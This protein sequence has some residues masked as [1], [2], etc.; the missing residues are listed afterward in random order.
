MHSRAT[1]TDKSM[2]SDY[3]HLV[4]D[5]HG[6]TCVISRL[7]QR[8]APACWFFVAINYFGG[9]RLAERRSRLDSRVREDLPISQDHAERQ[10]GADPSAIYDSS[11]EVL[12]AAEDLTNMPSAQRS[13]TICQTRCRHPFR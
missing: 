5:E 7:A 2:F 10:H 4:R 9:V 12:E 13:L 3:N 8:Y 6:L 11:D 1:Q